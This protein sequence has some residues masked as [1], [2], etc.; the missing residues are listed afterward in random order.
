M[1]NFLCYTCTLAFGISQACALNLSET[2][3]LAL[4]NS[5]RLREADAKRSAIN[6]SKEQGIAR[7]LPTLS[8]NAAA[9]RDWLHN[10]KAGRDFRG[11]DPNQEYWNQTFNVNLK[12]PLFHWD[13]WIQLSQSENQAARAEATYQAEMQNLMM[14]TCEA[15]FNVL[16]AQDNLE[17]SAAEKQAISRQLEQAKDRYQVGLIAD[18]DVHEAQAGF[19]QALAAEIEA[20]NNFE[21]QKDALN[22]IIGD[23]EETLASLGENLPLIKPD[24]IDLPAWTK[25]AE[26]NNLEIIA[27][28][29]QAEYLRKKID[30]QQNDHL[31]TLDLVASYGVSDVN[32]SFGLRGDTQSVGLQFNMNLFEGGAVSSRVRQAGYEFKAA[33]ENLNQKKLE[34]KRLVKEAYRGVIANISQ[35][36]ALKSSVTSAQNAL[37]ATEAGFDIGTRSMV[38]VLTEQKNLYRAK[39]EYSRSRY[40]YLINSL[41]LKYSASNLSQEDLQKI[42]SLLVSQINPKQ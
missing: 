1:R 23:A 13:H 29:N 30:L 16:A 42:N 27:A 2:Y 26:D 40:D 41:K 34:L 5:P 15:Y 24:P 4:Q 36:E 3:Q 22:V 21:I 9:S 28:L 10:K 8:I 38:E 35:V 17:Y 11:N 12:Q 33:T 18:I 31:P 7:F 37:E 39:R 19:D 14:N 6:E 25:S 32:S 20:A